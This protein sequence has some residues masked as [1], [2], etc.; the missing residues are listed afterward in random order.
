MINKLL[1]HAA[2]AAFAVAAV[3]G[4]GL[5]WEVT[6]ARQEVYQL[7]SIV[8]GRTPE[9][10]HRG[11]AKELCEALAVA[12]VGWRCVDPYTLPGYVEHPDRVER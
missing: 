7:R 1:A 12:N 8:V 10:F 2:Y 9:G 6:A 4:A 11:D 5:L 3:V